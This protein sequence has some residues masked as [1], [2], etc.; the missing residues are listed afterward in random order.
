M[1]GHWAVWDMGSTAHHVFKQTG[2]E[3]TLHR[4]LGNLSNMGTAVHEFEAFSLHS[5]PPQLFLA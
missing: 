4:Q 2:L 3:A 1:K 5:L